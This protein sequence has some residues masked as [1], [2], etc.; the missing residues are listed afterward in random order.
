MN[1]SIHLLYTIIL[2]T[3]ICYEMS[4]SDNDDDNGDEESETK[5][6]DVEV[7][8]VF[9]SLHN[10]RV[11]RKTPKMPKNPTAF[12]FEY[13]QDG[14]MKPGTASLGHGIVIAPL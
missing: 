10:P 12:G 2:F 13:D 3:G 11:R 4:Y 6:A 9:M 5:L 14:D 1:L 8:E 7:E